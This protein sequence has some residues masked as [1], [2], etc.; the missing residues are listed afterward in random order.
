MIIRIIISGIRIKLHNMF[1]K[2]NPITINNWL[3]FLS[4]YFCFFQSKNVRFRKKKFFSISA[5]SSKLNAI[6]SVCISPVHIIAI[7]LFYGNVCLF[8]LTLYPF[9]YL[10]WSFWKCFAFSWQFFPQIFFPDAQG[11]KIEFK[12]NKSK[13]YSFIWLRNSKTCYP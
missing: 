3:F 10:N 12:K 2:L 6:P 1:L 7:C 13:F 11:W 4:F 9:M 8:V 5:I